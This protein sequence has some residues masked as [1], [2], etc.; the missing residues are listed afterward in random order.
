M[1][2]VAVKRAQRELYDAGEYYALSNVLAPAAGVLVEKTGVA[3]GT[4]VLDVGAGDG[5]VATAAARRGAAVMATDLS[6]EQVQRGVA[7][8]R[9]EGLT[10]D[11]QVADVEQL[12][13]A[14]R[15]FSHV[16]S[17]F[18]AVAAPHPE[19]AA[20]EMFRVCRPGGAVALTAWPP[21]S[22]MAEL[23][24]AVRRATPADSHSLT[25]SWSGASRRS[26]ASASRPTPTT[27]PAPA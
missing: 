16:L 8:C 5:N 2:P 21:G 26:P 25:R 1:D 15:S 3:A 9:R 24:D 22:F 17:A 11:W 14:D 6:P 20:R 12:P 4:D 23:T 7:R 27:S 10:V 19:V 13:F 18:A